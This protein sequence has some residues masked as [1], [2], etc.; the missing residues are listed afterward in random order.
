MSPHY[1]PLKTKTKTKATKATKM[2]KRQHV[3]SVWWNFQFMAFRNDALITFGIYVMHRYNRPLTRQTISSREGTEPDP[4]ERQKLSLSLSRSRKRTSD[5]R[6]R[7]P[8]LIQKQR[9]GNERRKAKR[10][11]CIRRLTLIV[12]KVTCVTGEKGKEG[13]V[14]GGGRGG[15]VRNTGGNPNLSKIP[16]RW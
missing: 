16:L 7:K 3:F 13:A 12:T 1:S 10:G 14:R 11:D 6:K 2:R 5:S 15:G 4:R 9:V 8:F